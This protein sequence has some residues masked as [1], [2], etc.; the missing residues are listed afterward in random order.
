MPRNGIQMHWRQRFFHWCQMLGHKG[1]FA[2]PIS[3]LLGHKSPFAGPISPFARP[4]VQ[5][6][7][8]ANFESH[9]SRQSCLG[10]QSSSSEFSTP[11]SPWAHLKRIPN[12]YLQAT[13][14]GTRCGLVPFK[15]ACA[16][17]S[18][19][20]VLYSIGAGPQTWQAWPALNNVQDTSLCFF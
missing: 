6:L 14:T 19:A 2:G 11:K 1:P 15:Q 20:C 13:F 3:P 7:F 9:F 12:L 4:G 18:G 8:K 16:K 10:T 5:P 17:P